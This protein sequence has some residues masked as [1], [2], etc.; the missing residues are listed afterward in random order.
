MPSS[1]Q[2]EECH[3]MSSTMDLHLNMFLMRGI[4]GKCRKTL[5]GEIVMD[6]RGKQVMEFMC[7]VVSN[8]YKIVLLN[9]KIKITY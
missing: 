6:A 8:L 3:D 9:L 1:D 4:I 5:R 2:C 7:G